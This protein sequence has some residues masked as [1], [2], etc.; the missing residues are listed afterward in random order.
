MPLRWRMAARRIYW[1]VTRAIKTV[2]EE[3]GMR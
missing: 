2:E 1:V 3:V